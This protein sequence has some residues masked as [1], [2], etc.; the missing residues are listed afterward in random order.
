VSAL[1]EK[2]KSK[3]GKLTGMII[4]ESSHVKKG[5]HSVGVAR[6]YAGSVGKVDNCQ[7]VAYLSLC[8]GKRSSLIDE[9]LFLPQEWAQGC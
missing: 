4:D 5:K 6:Q 7:V 2:E 8:N 9:A 3:T 1:L